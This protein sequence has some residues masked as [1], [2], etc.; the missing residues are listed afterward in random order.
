IFS[1]LA[2]SATQS[3]WQGKNISTAAGAKQLLRKRAKKA[4]SKKN[5]SNVRRKIA[6]R[7]LPLNEGRLSGGTRQVH[8]HREPLG[9]V[10]YA[11]SSVAK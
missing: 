8:L 5:Y 9:T 3:L 6:G 2:Q 11:A 10:A 7:K 4:G 1:P